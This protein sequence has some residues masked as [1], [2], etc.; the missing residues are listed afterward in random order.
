MLFRSLTAI[1]GSVSL[2]VDERTGKINDLQKEML[3]L[4]QRNTD[5]LARMIDDLLEM[6]RSEAGKPMRVHLSKF[7]LFEMLADII[8]LFSEQ[9]S[10]NKLKLELIVPDKMEKVEADS[11]KIQQVVI[12]LIGNAIKFTPEDGV[13][14]VTAFD[15][16]DKWEI[17]VSDTGIGIPG[18]ELSKVF[19]SYHQV[20]HSNV[21]KQSKGFGLGLAISKRII[22]AHKGTIWVESDV[23]QGSRFIFSVPRNQSSTD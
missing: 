19:D 8:K 6:S 14:K 17:A 7:S 11:A 20:K 3:T 1:K 15:K 21:N 4:V 2:V 23:G 18:D 16:V 5:R 22:E 10:Q 9:A 12:N 13:V